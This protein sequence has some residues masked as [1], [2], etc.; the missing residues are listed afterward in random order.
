MT[1]SLPVRGLIEGAVLASLVTVLAIA[2]QAI[3]LVGLAASFLCPVP[4]TV[5]II[6][7]GFKVATLATVVATILG[8]AIAGLLVGAI[9]LLAY[10]PVGFALGIGV[11]ARMTASRLVAVTAVAIMASLVVSSVV[12]T[13]GLGIDPRITARKTIEVSRA[14]F[15]A[16]LER[17]RP[18]GADSAQVEAQVVAMHAVYDLLA[19]AIPV[20]LVLGSLFLAYLHFEVSRAILRRVGYPIPALPPMSMW[21]LPSVALWALPFASLGLLAAGRF[22]ALETFALTLGLVMVWA[23]L[24]QGILAGWVLME[25]FRLPSWYRAIVLVLF[26]GGPAGLVVFLLGAADALF[27]LRRRWRS[28][29]GLRAPELQR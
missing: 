2:A 5:L 24:G 19:R 4:L 10:A 9:I 22:P 17:L 11:R 13:V 8:S 26:L 25:R 16:T 29:V 7:H 14:S 6:R 18:Q 23:L 28:A 27:D 21:G 20:V 12:A 3:P 15:D 1:R